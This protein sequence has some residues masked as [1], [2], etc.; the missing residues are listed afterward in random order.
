LL[1]LCL[2]ISI[3]TAI[4]GNNH[5]NDSMSNTEIVGDTTNTDTP[6]I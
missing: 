3:G 2:G 4:E 5:A 1:I 6:Q